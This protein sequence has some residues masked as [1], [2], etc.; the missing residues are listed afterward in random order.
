M[1]CVCVCVRACVR[2]CVRVCVCVCGTATVCAEA[3]N[4]LNFYG[5]FEI[6]VDCLFLVRLIALLSLQDK[7]PDYKCIMLGDFHFECA[8]N[9][10][11]FCEFRKPQELL[12][13]VEY[14]DQVIR[15]NLK[16]GKAAGADNITTEH[17]VYAH[18]AVVR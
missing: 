7:H 6:L 14:V 8:E 9:R 16:F 3:F 17:L 13:S 18:P 4:R 12:L 5:L 15:N 11:G 1:V 2:A 10:S